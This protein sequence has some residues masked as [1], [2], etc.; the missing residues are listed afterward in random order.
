M[1]GREKADDG[2]QDTE[3]LRGSAPADDRIYDEYRLKNDQ[4][5]NGKTL[6]KQTAEPPSILQRRNLLSENTG[7]YP[8]VITIV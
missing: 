3:E 2:H 7:N 1:Q 6:E 4:S 5:G 8:E